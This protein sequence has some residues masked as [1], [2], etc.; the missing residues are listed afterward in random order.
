MILPKE[1]QEIFFET[2]YG[3]RT[4]SEF[5]QWL[6]AN[7]QLEHILDREAYLD[8]IS[9][10]YKDDRAPHGL[11]T[12]LEKYIHEG[13]YKLWKQRRQKQ[14]LIQGRRDTS[15]KTPFD[16]QLQR[17]QNKLTI[18]KNADKE[19]DGF[20]SEDHE[21][22]LNVPAFEEE[23]LAFENKY[24]IQLPPCYRSFLL[25]VGNGGIGYRDSGAG[26]F[27]GIYPLGH[28]INDLVPGDEANDCLL[29]PDMTT[30]Q[31]K[32]MTEFSRSSSKPSK[33]DYKKEAGKVFGGILP[34]GSQGCTYLHGI[35]LNG[36]HKG[37]VV[38]L[39]FDY[40]IPPIFA[41]GSNF[42]DWY[43]KWLDEVID[44]TQLY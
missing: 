3:D 6:Y 37:R 5:E 42:L 30:D 12:L 36:L 38:N 9:Y 8:L 26:P 29:D 25:K 7:S 32:S 21:Y 17:I 39:D 2:L 40:S 43:E 14:P 34:L 24:G 10:G 16:E 11:H 15:I 20:G 44:G 23:V 28:H 13:E 33:E 18:A 41:C 22:L 19:Y 27:F 1:I 4:V 31:W 35:I